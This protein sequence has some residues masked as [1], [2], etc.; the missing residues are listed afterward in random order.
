MGF[1]HGNDGGVMAVKRRFMVRVK[2][3]TSLQE[4]A[5]LAAMR[6]MTCALTSEPLSEPVGS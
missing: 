5:E 4:A 1:G 6:W 2:K 3:D